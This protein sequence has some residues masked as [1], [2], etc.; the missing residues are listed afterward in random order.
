MHLLWI[1]V[2]GAL[3]AVARYALSGWTY[4]GFGSRLPWGTLVVN[5]VGC[6][7]LGLLTEIALRTGWVS[8]E[9]RSAL[10][11]GFLGSL[12]TFSTFAVETWREIE[13]GGWAA[14][15]ANALLNTVG[16]LAFVVAGVIAARALLRLRGA[17]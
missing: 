13:R 10:A 11:I 5:L 15:L 9:V 6:F 4:A 7:F 1:A 16:G 2:G 3:G 14:A 8:A 12:T 17:P